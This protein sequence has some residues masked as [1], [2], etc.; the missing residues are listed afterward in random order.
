MLYILNYVQ[1]VGTM[2]LEQQITSYKTISEHQSLKQN[3]FTNQNVK[4][5]AWIKQRSMNFLLNYLLFVIFM[6]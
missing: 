2:L 1:F 5:I 4:K 3:S 6:H